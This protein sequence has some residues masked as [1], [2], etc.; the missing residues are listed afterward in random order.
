MK[1]HCQNSKKNDGSSTAGLV[2]W[3]KLHCRESFWCSDRFCLRKF[4]VLA[5]KGLKSGWKCPCYNFEQNGHAIILNEMKEVHKMRLKLSRGNS[6]LNFSTE[7]LAKIV[8]LKV[9]NKL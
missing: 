9:W 6:E 1:T 5:L 8:L 7:N 2:F 4:W 3:Q